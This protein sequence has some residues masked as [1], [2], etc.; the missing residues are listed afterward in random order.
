MKFCPSCRNMLYAIDEDTIDGTKCAVLSC[1]RC[2]Y[3]EPVSANN[4]LVYEHILRE[5]NTEKLSLNPYLEYDPTLEHY[6]NIVCTNA[7][8]ISRKS[9]KPDIVALLLDSKRLIWF[10]KCVHCKHMWKQTSGAM[11]TIY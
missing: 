3:K 9:V 8:C 2:E 7:E 5:D 11:K 6:S 1:R 4:P 10:Y